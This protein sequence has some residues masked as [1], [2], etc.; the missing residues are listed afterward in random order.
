[1]NSNVTNSLNIQNIPVK[2][3]H[4]GDIDIAYK[5][6]GKGDPFILISG[7][8]QVMG[9]WEPSILKEL[10]RNHTV[11]I[12]DNRGVGNTTLGTKPFSIQQFA[13]DTVSLL[14]ALKIQKADVLGFSMASFIAQEITLL[15]P[16]KVNRLILYGATCGGK[17]NIPQTPH[18][19]KILSDLVNNRTQ[20]P[21]K[22][23]SVTF[24]LEWV[25]SHP[26]VTIPKSK[27]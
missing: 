4:V 13:N 22:I 5:V 26:N 7:T 17:G 27:L 20:D 25:K 2:K 19:I 12:F 24:P 8:G 6:F 3:V 14:Y 9:A 21:E 18:V 23:L 15:H 1:M 16:E 11:I 10:S